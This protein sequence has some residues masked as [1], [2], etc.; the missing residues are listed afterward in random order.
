MSAPVKRKMSEEDETERPETEDARR[1]KWLTFR[2]F[3]AELKEQKRLRKEKIQINREKHEEKRKLAELGINEDEGSEDKE[4]LGRK[5]TVSIAVPASLLNNAISA[6]MR[7]YIAGQIGR[8]AG[9]FCVDEIVIY[10][11]G[12][13]GSTVEKPYQGP[14]VSPK[15]N[16]LLMARILQYLECPQYLRKYFFPV[17]DDLKFVG[18]LNPLDAPH[19]LRK[20]EVSVYREGVVLKKEG[21][22]KRKKSFVNVGLASNALLFQVAEPLQRVTVKFRCVEKQNCI[23]TGDPVPSHTPRTEAGKYWGYDLRLAPS[24]NAVFGQ[25]PY[26]DG[27]DLTIGVGDNGQSCDAVQMPSF[28]HAIIVFGGIQSVEQVLLKDDKLLVKDPRD[29]F[30]L[31]VNP[32]PVL[33]STHLRTEESL[34]TT[35]SVLK[36]KLVKAAA[37]NK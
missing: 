28:Q 34:L 31:F 36:P 9:V 12:E 5:W 1:E 19:H 4:D 32:F 15:K 24:F 2:K 37:P 7:T 10:N 35:L 21:V 30:D 25:S 20:E 8:A 17:H 26:D 11:D 29:L 33:N 16:M 14:E 18:L 23:L 27:Y 3:E 6:E 13:C 22:A